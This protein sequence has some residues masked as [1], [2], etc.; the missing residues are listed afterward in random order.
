MLLHGNQVGS[1]R[2]CFSCSQTSTED[3]SYYGKENSSNHSEATQGN[4]RGDGETTKLLASVLHESVDVLL[5]RGDCMVQFEIECRVGGPHGCQVFD[6]RLGVSGLPY[7]KGVHLFL[8]CRVYVKLLKAEV[9]LAN[10]N[11]LIR[12]GVREGELES[13][14]GC[15]VVESSPLGV[16][17]G[18]R[19]RLSSLV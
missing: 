7:E 3:T 16:L 5:G 17:A 6:P 14:T 1:S 4:A 11:G 19:A 2:G 15:E 10:I 12:A 8:P 13:L 18:K 9:N